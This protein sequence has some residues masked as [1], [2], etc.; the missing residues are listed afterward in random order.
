[1]RKALFEHTYTIVS[2]RW[3]NASFIWPLMKGRLI[4]RIAW[5]VGQM[6]FAIKYFVPS[7]TLIDQC[8][9]LSRFASPTNSHSKS[10]RHHKDMQALFVAWYN[11]GR[12]HEA[13]KGKTPA[14][15]SK[16]TDHVWTIKELI[17]K[18]AQ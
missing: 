11:F 1:L 10:L 6:V 18:A 3:Q 12:K 7:I 4:S 9:R 15:A 5:A 2:S 17:E 14:M 8:P 13:L 16:L